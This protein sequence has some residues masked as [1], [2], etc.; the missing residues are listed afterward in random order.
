MGLPRPISN[1][2]STRPRFGPVGSHDLGPPSH[3]VR[4]VTRSNPNLIFRNPN[5]AHRI[6]EIGSKILNI[7][8]SKLS[9]IACRFIKK[10]NYIQNQAKYIVVT[11]AELETLKTKSNMNQS[12]NNQIKKLI[13]YQSNW[14][15]SP[16]SKC[17]N[18]LNKIREKERKKDWTPKLFAAN[19]NPPPELVKFDTYNF[20]LNP[21]AFELSLHHWTLQ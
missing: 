20:T 3:R 17:I 13:I 7:L 4:T 18:K 16:N 14:I 11:F 12:N 6:K 5:H 10:Q 19:S 2:V 8:Q 21:Q 9:I 15:L 1:W